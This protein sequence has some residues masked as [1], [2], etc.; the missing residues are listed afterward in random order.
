MSNIRESQGTLYTPDKTL[1]LG[2]EVKLPDYIAFN[3]ELLVERPF[4]K[5]W[6]GT[7]HP[8]I[9]PSIEVEIGWTFGLHKSCWPIAPTF[10]HKSEWF[11]IDEIEPVII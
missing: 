4:F 1:K 9:R 2:Q 6:R 10:Q 5:S 3:D 8:D 11:N 7:F